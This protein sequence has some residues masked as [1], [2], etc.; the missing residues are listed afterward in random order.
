MKARGPEAK[1]PGP[2]F[3][4]FLVL[5]RFALRGSRS[6]VVPLHGFGYGPVDKA[7]YTSAVGLFWGDKKSR[8]LHRRGPLE[9]MELSPI[10]YHEGVREAMSNEE[11]VALIQGGERE[12]LPDLWEQVERFV[13]QQAHRRFVLSA[14]LGGGKGWTAIR[15]TCL[16]YLKAHPE[17]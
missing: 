4:L 8:T 9:D 17:G 10:F 11:L 7:V 16:R 15:D 3:C 13:R 5:L 6:A 12:R 2:L 14:G 1:S